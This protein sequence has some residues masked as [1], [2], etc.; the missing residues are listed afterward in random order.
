M[1]VKA[2]GARKGEHG[3][4]MVEGGKCEGGQGCDGER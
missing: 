4:G 3:K 1:T 2:K